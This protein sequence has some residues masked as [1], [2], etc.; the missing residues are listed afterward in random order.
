LEAQ[1]YSPKS[2]IG[3]PLWA[4]EHQVSGQGPSG[5][6]HPGVDPLG[7]ALEQP[8]AVERF[9]P[10]GEIITYLV[11]QDEAGRWII[12]MGDH[13]Y[14]LYQSQGAAVVRAVDTAKKAVTGGYAP[15]VVLRDANG[16][17][18]DI[19]IAE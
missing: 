11:H 8:R 15:R 6:P 17:E 19:S 13:F 18:S 12:G 7:P 14:G 4:R 3:R 5:R 1:A 2:R 9:G 10:I 16:I